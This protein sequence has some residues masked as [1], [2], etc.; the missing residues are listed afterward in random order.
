MRVNIRKNLTITIANIYLPGSVNFECGEMSRIISL[1][2][3]PKIIV[4]DFHAHNTVR[5]TYW[6]RSSWNKA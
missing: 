4:G 2:P 3:N 5:G 1:L 6:K